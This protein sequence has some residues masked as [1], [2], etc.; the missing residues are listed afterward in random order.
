M[1]M[2]EGKGSDRK[3]RLKM[4]REIRITGLLF[5]MALFAL[6]MPRVFTQIAAETLFVKTYT[7]EFMPY[8]YLAEALI[9]PI[10]GH[11]YI[12][13]DESMSVRNL[14]ASTMLI[15]LVMLVVLWLGFTF[16]EFRAVAFAGMVWFEAEA[17]FCSLWVWGLA[18]QILT[19]REGKKYFGI[20]IAGEPTA[21]IIG[22]LCAPLLL[23]VVSVQ[24][25]F[26]VS[27]IGVAVG[28]ALCF[29]I[30]SKFPPQRDAE[31]DEEEDGETEQQGA[32]PWYKERYVQILVSVV[33]LAQFCYFFIDSAFFLEAEEHYPTEEALGSFIGTVQAAIGGVS[34][35]ISL[36][37]A[38]PLLKRF[39]LRT[40]LLLLPTLT[41]LVAFSVGF[42]GLALGLASGV[43]GLTV[44]LKM[45]DIAVRY[46]I[47]KTASV[48]L[49]QPLP[50]SQRNQV[51][52]ALESVIE[53]LV[54]GASGIILVVLIQWLD[55]GAAGI[56]ALIGVLAVAWLILV[57]A[58][59]GF[60]Q[61]ALRSA[62]QAR[63]FGDG[64]LTID[65]P[66]A[67]AT[68]T[69][70]LNNKN[71]GTV[72]NALSLIDRIEDFDEVGCYTRLLNHP[73][74]AVRLEVLRRIE[75]LG[76][77]ALPTGTIDALLT[78]E[79]DSAVRAQAM[80]TLA[81]LD[82]E[83]AADQLETA[84]SSSDQTIRREAFVGL[85]RYCGI[86]GVLGAGQPLMTLLQSADPKDRLFATSVLKAVATP[87]S[88]R[89]LR[90]LMSDQEPSVRAAALEAVSQVRESALWP[91]AVELLSDDDDKVH[92]A[93]ANIIPIAGD[94]ALGPLTR[95]IDTF[96]STS[97]TRQRAARALGSI[98]SDAARKVMIERIDTFDRKVTQELLFAIP[99]GANWLLD[100]DMRKKLVQALRATL[101]TS[102]KTIGWR[103][104][105]TGD[106]STET[107]HASLLRA[108]SD[109]IDQD[110]KSIF[111]LVSLLYPQSGL[112]AAWQ[113]YRDGD[114]EKQAFAIEAVETSID[115]EFRRGI[116]AL[117]EHET[118]TERLRA[119][120]IEFRPKHQLAAAE[121]P[122]AII[123]ASVAT[124]VPWTRAVALHVFLRRGGSLATK[125][126]IL[127]D[128]PLCREMLE[129][130]SRADRIL[131]V[132]K[133]LALRDTPIFADVREEHLVDV[134]YRAEPVE[135]EEGVPLFE[136]GEAG[137][138]MF[139][140]VSGKLRIHIDGKALAEVG[141][142]DVV[143]EMA[144]VDP[145][146]RSASAHTL[147]KSLLLRI[148]H[149]NLDLLI[150]HD[151]DVARGIIKVLCRRLRGGNKT[152]TAA[153]D[154]EGTAAAA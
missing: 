112:E 103:I 134:A 18:T 152:S 94:A 142:G 34:L 52:T 27:A 96:E 141:S 65:D 9:V 15:D 82:P 122:A 117:L 33:V 92:R 10:L 49:L 149:S 83:E 32:K 7:A 106:S 107:D 43:F 75:N 20:I 137:N 73:E 11:F 87:G 148:S 131:T 129:S 89:Q 23:D 116:L 13:A 111:R 1:T 31:G 118:D 144:A 42:T 121:V 63:R 62:F 126:A 55:V 26:L 47:D 68:I 38:G 119:L 66:E 143:G 36:F 108:L 101:A 41:A 123:D 86:E 24:T 45:V 37:L 79:A 97:A 147:E 56:C 110:V 2:V 12:K 16:T 114:A 80:R 145:E 19:L 139:V 76:H 124:I 40:T 58:Q 151:P 30:T 59:D 14:I 135:L 50:A 130:S 136:R 120:P 85:L 100:D 132:E 5:L 61:R 128:N 39:G 60:Y 77:G 95:L 109:E 102:G 25:L 84:L 70:A 69:E 78:T 29:Y 51:A 3:L 72:L 153:K 53:P 93:A 127:L 6:G 46:T 88:G 35:V 98:R 91:R 105:L 4:S 71:A 150:D 67:V 154:A 138:S 8:A 44:V 104:A 17:V 133:V 48:T 64:G 57:F 81:A 125:P 74:P 21:V 22:G 28:I 54:G 146:P 115:R 140:V 113:S 90:R 99:T